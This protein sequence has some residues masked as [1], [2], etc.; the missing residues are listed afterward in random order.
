MAKWRISVQPERIFKNCTS[1]IKQW[2]LNTHGMYPWKG[3]SKLLPKISMMI[4]KEKKGG[5][6]KTNNS[7]EKQYYQILKKEYPLT[8]WMELDGRIICYAY[9]RLCERIPFHCFSLSVHSKT[10]SKHNIEEPSLFQVVLLFVGRI[11]VY[12]W[13]LLSASLL[14]KDYT[15]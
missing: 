7:S 12:V 1:Q 10:Y 4:Q 9:L 11:I 13:F 14:I 8:G 15:S 2:V 6:M 3:F 5:G